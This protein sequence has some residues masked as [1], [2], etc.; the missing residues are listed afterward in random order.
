[1]SDVVELVKDPRCECGSTVTI[2]RRTVQTW[3]GKLVIAHA[4]C[5]E[6]P[7]DG[8]AVPQAIQRIVA[9]PV[10]VRNPVN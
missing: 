1:M 10:R 6:H 2:R 4:W 3:S 5:T 8:H 9:V 7:G